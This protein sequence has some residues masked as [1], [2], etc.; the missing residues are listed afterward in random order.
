VSQN[1]LWKTADDAEWAHGLA[2]VYLGTS[3]AYG[4]HMVRW[5]DIRFA[6]RFAG[7]PAPVR[8]TGSVYT[9]ACWRD[10]ARTLLAAAIAVLVLVCL[11][12][13]VGNAAQTVALQGWFRVA[14][15]ICGVELLRAVRYTIWPRPLAARSPAGA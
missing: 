3:I 12:W 15:I 14:L 10:V 8:A 2:A 7:G 5:A 4:Q 13:L 9:V 1:A 6:H 11:I